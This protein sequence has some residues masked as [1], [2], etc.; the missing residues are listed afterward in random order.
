[1]YIAIFEYQT[2]KELPYGKDLEGEI[3]ISG[4]TVMK[5]YL[6]NPLATKNTLMKHSDGKY[7]VHTD[8]MGVMDSDGYI[9]HRGRLKRMLTRSGN[10]LWLTDLDE[11]VMGTGLVASCCS[12]KLDDINER[13]VPV[14]H[15]VLNEG[16]DEFEV[17]SKLDSYI[18]ENCP[19]FYLPKYY[20]IKEYL[21]YTKVNKK[22]D[23]KSLEKE[24]ILDEDEFIINGK[25]IKPRNK[26]KKLI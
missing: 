9:Y 24:N 25:I 26:I 1:M 21:P 19:P 8:D 3:C 15:V 18:K 11:K 14:V 10:K 20:I 23:F 13:E 2:D 22:L 7:W 16:E 6:N 12:V 4:P 5:G 17:I